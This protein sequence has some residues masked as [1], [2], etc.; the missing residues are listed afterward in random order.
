MAKYV[1]PAFRMII[2]IAIGICGFKFLGGVIQ[3]AIS[4]AAVL[5]LAL[6][7]YRY[8]FDGDLSLIPFINSVKG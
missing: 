1:E 7:A 8:L 2:C 6:M 5:V 4:I 3:W